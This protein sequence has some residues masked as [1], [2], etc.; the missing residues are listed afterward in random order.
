MRRIALIE[1]MDFGLRFV[2]LA[3][4]IVVVKTRGI[5][6]MG[7]KVRQGASV[8]RAPV[9]PTPDI[10]DCFFVAGSNFDDLLTQLVRPVEQRVI[11]TPGCFCVSCEDVEPLPLGVFSKRRITSSHNA[12]YFPRLA[13]GSGPSPSTIV[14]WWFG[15]IGSSWSYLGSNGTPIRLAVLDASDCGETAGGLPSARRR[16]PGNGPCC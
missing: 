7:R 16:R 15:M 6:R 4:A 13:L 14:H 5:L 1:V 11:H 12:A 10:D 2:V 8:A 9:W 3:L